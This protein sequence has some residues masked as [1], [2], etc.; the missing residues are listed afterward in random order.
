MLLGGCLA[1]ACGGSDPPITVTAIQVGRARNADKSISAPTFAF[2]PTDTI[3]AAVITEGT[4]SDAAI[5]ARWTYGGGVVGEAEQK[6]SQRG[7]AITGFELRNAGG[8]PTGAYKLE[9]FLD[10]VPSG[11][12]DLRVAP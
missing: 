7:S 5:T 12:R 4:G 3:Y 10:G 6:V 8:F 9:V 2:K 1:V 11:T